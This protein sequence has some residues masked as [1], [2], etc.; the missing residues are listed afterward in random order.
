MPSI[1]DLNEVDKPMKV[2]NVCILTGVEMSTV[3][4]LDNK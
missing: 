3:V 2:E 1:W 4:H